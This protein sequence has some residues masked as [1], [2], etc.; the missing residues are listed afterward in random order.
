M[1]RSQPEEAREEIRAVVRIQVEQ[2]RQ[3]DHYVIPVPAVLSWAR[4]A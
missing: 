3:G 1:L 2:L 4:K